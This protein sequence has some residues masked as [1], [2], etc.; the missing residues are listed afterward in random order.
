MKCLYWVN[1]KGERLSVVA[2]LPS[3]VMVSSSACDL[4][5]RD[6]NVFTA[7]EIPNVFPQWDRKFF[8]VS[9]AEF[10][11]WQDSN[12][13]NEHYSCNNNNT[14]NYNNFIQLTKYVHNLQKYLK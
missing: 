2:P 1:W 13:N 9:G 7:R 5:F 14:N 6:P 3:P 4:I 11:H 8:K 12:N 10:E